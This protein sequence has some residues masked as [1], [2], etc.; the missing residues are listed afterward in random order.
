MKIHTIP[1][2]VASANCYLVWDEN[3]LIVIDPGGEPEKLLDE[4]EKTQAKPAAILLT[5]GHFDHVGAVTALKNTHDL[6]VYLF[7]EDFLYVSQPEKAYS[8]AFLRLAKEIIFLPEVLMQKEETLRFGGLHFQ[9]LHTPGHTPGSVC[10][11]CEDALFTGDTL[12]RGT[13]GR[14]DLFGADKEKLQESFER[15]RNIPEDLNVFPGH[16]QETSLSFEKKTNPFLMNPKGEV[17][18]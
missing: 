2:G 13:C 9:V 4:M 11:L 7:A 15:L 6:P 18:T 10:Y 16:G 17:W 3:Q 14:F 8:G 12:F 1:V 5:H